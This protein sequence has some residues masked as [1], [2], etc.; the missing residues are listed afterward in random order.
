M[1]EPLRFPAPP[2]GGPMR[3]S[4]LGPATGILEA[5]PAGVQVEEVPFPGQIALRGRSDD[6]A[7][8]EAVERVIGLRLPA[9]TGLVVTGPEIE[10]LALGPDE[11]LAV[12]AAGQEKKLVPALERALAGRSAAVVDVTDALTVFHLSGGRVHDLLAKGCPLDLHPRAFPPGRC[13]RSLLGVVPVILQRL[14]ADALFRLY[15]APSDARNLVAWLGD[16][17]AEY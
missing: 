5:L 15:A 16:H 12:L 2:A 7:F 1:A 10:V 8:Q 17:S 4:P 13:A 6:S 11:W 9:G 3:R 14:E